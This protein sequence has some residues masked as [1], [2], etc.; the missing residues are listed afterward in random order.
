M[1]SKKIIQELTKHEQSFLCP[2]P[3]DD[4]TEHCLR[5]MFA[6]KYRKTDPFHTATC[7]SWLGQPYTTA[8]IHT[9]NPLRM[10]RRIDFANHSCSSLSKL[11]KKFPVAYSPLIEDLKRRPSQS[12][13]EIPRSIRQGAKTDNRCRLQMD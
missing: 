3:T 2:T 11:R 12:H 13:V 5:H 8:S 7:E 10:D 9:G 4:Y 6:G 1:E